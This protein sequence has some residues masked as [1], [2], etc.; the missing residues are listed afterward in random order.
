MNT[1]YRILETDEA[2]K[3]V[4]HIAVEAYEYTKD[5][6]SGIS[7]LSFYDELV[8]SLKTFPF[9]FRGVSLEHRGY[10]IHIRPFRNYNLFFV[11]DWRKQE[12]VILRALY[13]KQDW[14]RILRLDDVYHFR[15]RE[16]S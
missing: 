4:N 14:E 11:V 10:E 6:N 3:D 2:L 8:N 13:Q 1:F 15:G 16:M 12:I 9:K 5:I 7:F